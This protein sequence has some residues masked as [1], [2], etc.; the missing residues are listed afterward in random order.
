MT[1]HINRLDYF[2][3]NQIIGVQK[4]NLREKNVKDF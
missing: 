1:S 4:Q 3:S 2:D